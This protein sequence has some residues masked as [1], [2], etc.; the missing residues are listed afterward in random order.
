MP[1]TSSQRTVQPCDHLVGGC[2]PLSSRLEGDEHAS[3]VLGDCRP[4]GSDIGGRR[5]DRRILDRPRRARLLAVHHGLRRD[6]LARPPK[7]RRSS[8]CPAAGRTL[9]ELCTN[10][11]TVKTTV[12]IMTISVTRGAAARLDERPVVDARAAH[13]RNAREPAIDAAVLLLPSGVSKP[14]AHHRRQRQ[15]D[16]RP[17]RRS[18]SH[19]VTANSRNSRPTMPLIR[20]QR[21]EHGD[22]R[23]R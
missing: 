15:R 6:V 9:W 5:S 21:N 17:K 1:W 23:Y 22:Q 18:P 7:C 10:R 12:Q 2:A 16:E 8:R 20:K 14:R 13:R 4:S 3:V 19:S 11:T